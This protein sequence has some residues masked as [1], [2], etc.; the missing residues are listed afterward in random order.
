MVATIGT[1]I[2]AIDIEAIITVIGIG[3]VASTLKPDLI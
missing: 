1:A 3:V 2:V